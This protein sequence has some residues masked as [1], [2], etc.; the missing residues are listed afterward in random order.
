MPIPLLSP[1]FAWLGALAVRL[2]LAI[3][4]TGPIPK[5]CAFV[6]DGNRRFARLRG[7]PVFDGH[8]EGFDS[9][10]RVCRMLS[11][12]LVLALGRPRKESSCL[13][14]PSVP[15]LEPLDDSL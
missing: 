13:P 5:H 15:A 8:L 10:K 3:L 12:C 4:R 6:M 1:A 9:L 14:P 2:L 11:P 7:R